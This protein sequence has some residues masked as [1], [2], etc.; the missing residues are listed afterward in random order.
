LEG[1]SGSNPTS[2]SAESVSA[3]YSRGCRRR[4]LHFCG[5]LR[6]HGD[7]RRDELAEHAPLLAVFL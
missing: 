6:R 3:L 2:S 5:S 4:V 1:T 7:E